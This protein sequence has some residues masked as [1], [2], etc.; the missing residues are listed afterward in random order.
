M[1]KLSE[2]MNQYIFPALSTYYEEPLVLEK[3]EGK[4]LYDDAG[5]QYLDFFGGI[6]TVSM[7]HCN[8]EIISRVVEQVRTLQHT[9]TV[10]IIRPMVELA[11]QIARIAPGKLQKCF[12]VNSGTEA[13]ET[14]VLLST[15]YTGNDEI[16]AL[17]HAYSGRSAL[18]MSLTA[19]APWRQGKALWANVKHA[20]SPYCYRCAFGRTY[21]NCD[22]E[23][24]KDIE[25]LIC[26]ST[27]G[28]IAAFIAEPIQGVGGFIT[29][30]KEYFAEAVSIIRKYGGLFIAD[31]VQTAWGRTGGKMFG[32]EHWGVE[33]DIMTF[34]K[35]LAN[36]AP[37]GAVIATSEV[38]DSWHGPT[39]STFGG[40]PVSMVAAQATLDL[41]VKN[42]IPAHVEKVGARLREGLL[43]LQEKYECIGDVRG[44]G[45]MQALELVGE[46]KVPAPDL[47]LKVFENT[48]DL[49]LLI[50]KGGLY[51]NVIR[52]T[53]PMIV[54][55]SDVDQAVEILDKAFALL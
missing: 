11:E 53:P 40:N 36:G 27:S 18:A 7:G 9:S 8:P 44:M 54:T 30:P 39:I 55:E 23:C 19:H 48:K 45:L 50:G 13:D 33:P 29:P 16:V 2:K 17:R 43:R 25:E 14:A 24:A 32:I 42:D 47:V 49:G 51:N 10:Y 1:H 41:I 4:Y 28:R 37:I 52:L 26:T 31:E 22:L 3:G 15:I 5:R 21:P 35:G 38:A 34:A 6:L 46:N 20:H 12:F